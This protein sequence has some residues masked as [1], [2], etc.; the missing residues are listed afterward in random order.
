M[1]IIL[2]AVFA[3]AMLFAGLPVATAS[4]WYMQSAPQ[5]YPWCVP[6][7]GYS[8]ESGQNGVTTAWDCSHGPQQQNYH[9]HHHRYWQQGDRYWNQPPV[10]FQYHICFNQFDQWGRY[11][12]VCI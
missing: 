8:G 11:V 1:R 5:P 3:A 4:A 12:Q 6:S 7:N 9:Q 10:Q 2:S